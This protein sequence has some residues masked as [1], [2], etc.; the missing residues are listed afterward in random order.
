MPVKK[1]PRMP[2]Y[3]KHQHSTGDPKYLYKYQDL[4]ET[5]FITSLCTSTQYE[6]GSDV[7]ISTLYGKWIPSSNRWLLNCVLGKGAAHLQGLHFAEWDS[8]VYRQ[9]CR[10]CVG[11]Q[12][13]TQT[14]PLLPTNTVPIL[15]EY[16]FIS[17]SNCGYTYLV[18][19]LPLSQ[20]PS[21]FLAHTTILTSPH[22]F[23]PL[24]LSIK[25]HA[26]IWA[27]LISS[28]VL[29]LFVFFISH[30]CLFLLW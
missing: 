18:P 29:G 30:N 19:N 9:Q 26:Q 11:H 13:L 1:S 10:G 21:L 28:T 16:Q 20:R 24:L 15:T 12:Q 8:H 17:M 22:V 2:I 6:L 27:L 14:R 5:A 25:T 7:M 4:G 23:L 3:T